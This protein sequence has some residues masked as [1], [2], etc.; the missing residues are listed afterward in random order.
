MYSG[1]LQFIATREKRNRGQV[2][3]VC[4]NS[5]FMYIDGVL[6]LIAAACAL[7]RLPESFS[8]EWYVGL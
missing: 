8:Y 3:S 7:R 6:N 2:S 1:V 4:G 5:C